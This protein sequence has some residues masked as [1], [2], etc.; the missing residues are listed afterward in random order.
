MRSEEIDI[1]INFLFSKWGV[2]GT[3]KKMVEIIVAYIESLEKQINETNETNL[4]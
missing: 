1:A 4:K 2:D 3:N